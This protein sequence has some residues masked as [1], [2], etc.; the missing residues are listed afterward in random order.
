[1]ADNDD[2]FRIIRDLAKANKHAE[3]T[4]GRPMVISSVQALSEPAPNY[5]GRF[6]DA[7]GTGETQVIIQFVVTDPVT[8][9]EIPVTSHL[10]PILREAYEK[11]TWALSMLDQ[12]LERE[13]R[14]YDWHK[15]NEQR[16]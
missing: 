2:A 3:L 6:G 12:R 1:L 10:E 9:K 14:E 16:G 11:V 8:G 5:Q 4:K 15:A 13:R 7:R